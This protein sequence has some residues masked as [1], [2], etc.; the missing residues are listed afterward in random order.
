ML[1]KLKRKLNRDENES[2]RPSQRTSTPSTNPHS[3][4]NDTANPTPW[5]G[6]KSFVDVLHK[7]TDSF[8]PLKS[9]FGEFSKCIEI[10][11]ASILLSQ[12]R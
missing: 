12:D 3:S 2:P 7:T 8:G 10:F 6:L 1:K 5:T 11:E 9:A 4:T